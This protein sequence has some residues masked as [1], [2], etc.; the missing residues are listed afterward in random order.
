M[1]GLVFVRCGGC[2]VLLIGV[3]LNIA[4]LHPRLLLT[5]DWPLCTWSLNE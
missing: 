4:L 3:R 1:A 5:S 2:V